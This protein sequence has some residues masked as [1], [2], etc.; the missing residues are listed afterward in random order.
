MSQ[1]VCAELC[2]KNMAITREE[3]DEYAIQSYQRSRSAAEQG[4]FRQEIV[5]VTVQQKKGR[6]TLSGQVVVCKMLCNKL[7]NKSTVHQHDFT[8]SLVV[9]HSFCRGE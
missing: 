9:W 8:V 5:P 3:Q 7:V 6:S 2:A 4:V 1:G